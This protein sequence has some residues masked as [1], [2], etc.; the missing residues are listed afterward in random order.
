MTTL[1]H[2]SFP[3][4]AERICALYDEEQEALLLGM[5]GREYLIRRDGIFMRGQK[6]P[7]AQAALIMDHLFSRGASCVVAPWRT[8][9]DFLGEP[10]PE[11]RKKTELPL[12]AYAE[13]IIA[14]MTGLLPMMDAE[15]TPSLIGSDFSM[16]ARALPNV[17]LRLELWQET[18]D[19][20]AEA[21]IL[22]SN[23]AH[24]FL[25]LDNLQVL[26]E[27]FKDRLLSLLR[28]Y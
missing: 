14:R 11:F 8:F 3:K 12:V 21:W 9:G 28:I 2:I 15:T 26:A 22:F 25:T 17:Y 27:M 18:Q 5:L 20:P 6:A 16:T 24:E 1:E 7:E 19:F 23:N 4:T 13:E 10:A